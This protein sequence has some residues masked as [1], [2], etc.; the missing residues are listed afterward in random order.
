MK[1]SLN[2]LTLKYKIKG[3]QNDQCVIYDKKSQ[4]F[5][6]IISDIISESMIENEEIT[7]N[8]GDNDG[9]NGIKQLNVIPRRVILVIDKSGSMAGSKWNK[10]MSST[11]IALQQL[12]ILYD[13]YNII[14]FNDKIKILSEKIMIANEE[15][16]NE[17]IHYLQNENA[18]GSTNIYDALSKAI[19]LIKNDIISLNISSFYMN[20]IIFITD[21][22]A[23]AGITD[24]KQIG[25]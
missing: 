16:I 12:R 13:R 9:K 8:E 20:Q 10:T 5:C 22:E 7:I 19:N 1:S 24:T 18:G 25:R 4:T 15:N 14:F 3:E 21:G 6:H 17:S 11:M 2:E 23:N